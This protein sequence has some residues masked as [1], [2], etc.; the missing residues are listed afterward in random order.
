[1]TPRNSET[2]PFAWGVPERGPR[3]CLVVRGGDACVSECLP[4]CSAVDGD[5]CD[6]TAGN[7]LR[8]LDHA[9]DLLLE[10]LVA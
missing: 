8:L 7:A 9:Q 4:N 10:G 3:K 2:C 1:M 5:R 6:V